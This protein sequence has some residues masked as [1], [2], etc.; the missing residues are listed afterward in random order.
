MTTPVKCTACDG[1]GWK[2]VTRRGRV[3]AT[4]MREATS[5]QEDCVYCDEGQLFVE[6][7]EWE[8]FL[9]GTGTDERGP[10]G[11]SSGQATSMDELRKALRRMDPDSEPW[12]RITHRISDFS[13]FPDNSSR[14]VIFLAT[15]DPAGSVRF[16]RVSA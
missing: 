12:G 9:T 1:R 2:I 10:C 7:F 3:T 15:L 5:S 16:E 14:R 13:A 6:M 11:A 8:T 4:M